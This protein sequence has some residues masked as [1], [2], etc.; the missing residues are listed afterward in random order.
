MD[1]KFGDS[2]VVRIDDRNFAVS[3]KG[4][5]RSTTAHTTYHPSLLSALQY[6]QTKKANTLEATTFPKYLKELRALNE[7]FLA[8][9]R[10]TLASV[11]H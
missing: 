7:A 3:I 1:F 6:L 4:S 10:T 2:R 8:E 5:G 11:K 9:L